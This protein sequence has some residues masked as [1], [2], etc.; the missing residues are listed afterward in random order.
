MIG[1]I[2]YNQIQ[3]YLIDWF[4]KTHNIL[5]MLVLFL[6]PLG[7]HWLKIIFFD[8]LRVSNG[9]FFIFDTPLMMDLLIFDTL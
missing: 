5:N 3:H 6:L 9:V 4:W 7:T 1:D 2:K 8:D